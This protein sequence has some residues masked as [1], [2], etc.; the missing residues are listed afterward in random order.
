MEKGT[1]REGNER[2]LRREHLYVH[3]NRKVERTLSSGALERKQQINVHECERLGEVML[4][5][6]FHARVGKQVNRMKSLGNTGEDKENV[7]GVEMLKFL[8]N[9]DMKTLNDRSPKPE[10]QW[11]WA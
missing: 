4:V 8:E 10:A 9:N 3:R 2:L 11:T 6:D 5:V 7:D 1:R